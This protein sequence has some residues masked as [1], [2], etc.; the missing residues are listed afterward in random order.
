MK[1]IPEYFNI[2]NLNNKYKENKFMGIGSLFKKGVSISMNGKCKQHSLKAS[3]YSNRA[4][5]S[6]RTAK[7]K[8]DINQKLDH[9]IDA[10]S[11]LSNAIMEVSNSVT[12]ISTMGMVSALLSEN[13]S[14]LLNEQTQEITSKKLTSR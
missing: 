12:P 2:I 7:S 10:M 1:K 14:D 3:N 8:K 11:H 9:V 13:I 6:L 4:V 5:S